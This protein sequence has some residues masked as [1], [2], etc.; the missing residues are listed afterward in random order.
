MHKL[1]G[2]RGGRIYNELFIND[3]LV[4][5]RLNEQYSTLL[6]NGIILSS[7]ADVPLQMGLNQDKALVNIIN[8]C[9]QRVLGQNVGVSTCK[10]TEI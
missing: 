6:E 8:N 3:R 5:D 4:S 9:R 1:W 7:E 2:R 10:M